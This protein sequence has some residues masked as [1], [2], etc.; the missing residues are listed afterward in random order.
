MLKLPW[1]LFGRDKRLAPSERWERDIK[2]V[3]HLLFVMP[4]LSDN[5]DGAGARFEPAPLLGS[6][7][8]TDVTRNKVRRATLGRHKGARYRYWLSTKEV[9]EVA[10]EKRKPIPWQATASGLR[11]L[12]RRLPMVEAFYAIVPELWSHPGIHILH[13]VA[14]DPG[15]IAGIP[16]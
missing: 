1:N 9:R 5:R 15:T 14:A 10:R 11:W 3:R 6:A 16:D 8:G 7:E 13:S 12:V 2:V 4:L